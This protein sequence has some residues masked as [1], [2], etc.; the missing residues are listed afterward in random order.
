M[1]FGMKNLFK[2]ATEG[3]V[4]FIYQEI[5]K[6]NEQIVNELNETGGVSQDKL[7]KKIMDEF[8]VGKGLAEQEAGEVLKRKAF[9]AIPKETR[10]S[11]IEEAKTK[12][13]ENTR[14]YEDVLSR[15]KKIPD[16]VKQLFGEPFSEDSVDKTMQKSVKSIQDL[17]D[18]ESPLGYELE[19]RVIKFKNEVKY[20]EYRVE[21]WEEKWEAEKEMKKLNK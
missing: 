9:E 11:K 13:D 4:K 7:E 8:D 21:D 12:M 1:N 15:A 14:R 10:I 20:F 2:S 5:R 19:K 6:S 3:S 17:Y 18:E 16:S